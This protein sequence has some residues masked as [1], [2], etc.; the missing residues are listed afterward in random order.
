MTENQIL[1]TR[2]QVESLAGIG[3]SLIYK[4]M[5]ENKFPR[6]VR[7]SDYAVR[8]K[9]SEILDWIES[10]PPQQPASKLKPHP[11]RPDVAEKKGRPGANANPL[12]SLI[13]HPLR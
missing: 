13:F 10:R 11:R 6:P 12:D 4:L 2:K 1:L 7:I 5:S 9:K 8:W 3:R